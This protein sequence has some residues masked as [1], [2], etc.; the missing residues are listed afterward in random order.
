MKKI[1]SI[2][3]ITCL[4]LATFVPFVSAASNDVEIISVT[5]NSTDDEFVLT[6][7]GKT[8]SAMNVSLIVKNQNGVLRAIEQTKTD[9]DGT[10]VYDIGV[11][12]T[13][14]KGLVTDPEQPLVYTLYARTRN[15]KNEPDGY[16]VPLYSNEAKQIYCNRF[17]NADT[18]TEETMINCIE[19]YNEVF[20]FGMAYYDAKKSEIEK[21]MIAAKTEEIF[22]ISNI[23]ERF[24]KSVAL[25]YLFDPDTS[26]DR[27]EII[28]YPSYSALLQ[29][30]TGFDDAD[31]LY[32]VYKSMSS[33]EKQN[34]NAIV[35]AESNKKFDFTELKE[36]FFMAITAERFADYADDY[37]VIYEFLKKYNGWFELDNFED[38]DDSEASKIISAILEEKIPDNKADFVKLYNKHYVDILGDDKPI[39]KPVTDGSGGGSGGGGGGSTSSGMGTVGYEPQPE[40]IQPTVTPQQTASFN[41]LAGYGWASDAITYL[42]GKGIVNGKGNNEFAPADNITREEFAKIL[43][44]AYD[45]YDEGAECD[46]IDAEKDRWSYKYIASLHKYGTV[47]GYPDGSFGVNNLISREEMAV[48]LYRILL[49]KLEIDPKITMDKTFN[50]MDNISE[51]AV[52][53][54]LMLGAN[55]V[56]SGDESGNFNPKK[57]ATRAEVCRMIYNSVAGEGGNK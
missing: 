23:L 28:E 42:A 11:V 49:N 35:F 6:V 31:S 47:Q 26:V 5:Y 37:T 20:G 30:N 16:D 56:I 52:N 34:V 32:P 8:A 17:N 33:T 27:T 36:E 22:T 7:K 18:D 41:D 53:S 50:D 43:V 55:G 12:I 14:D 9:V 48:M 46:F 2:F 4:L 40:V 57:G 24:D 38:L 10:F 39:K 1:I 45:L 25:A 21:N 19:T 13:E 3:T 15:Y 29:F 54:V 51:Y 44:L